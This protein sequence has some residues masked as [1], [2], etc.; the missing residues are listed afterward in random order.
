M[1]R[2]VKYQGR[3]PLAWVVGSVLAGVVG[4]TFL[5]GREGLAG[6]LVRVKGETGTFRMAVM[7]TTV[8]QYCGYLNRRSARSGENHPQCRRRAGRWVPRRGVARQPV[9]Y[10]SFD[11]VEA[12]CLWLAEETGLRVRLPSEEE[13]TIAA[14]AGDRRRKYPWGWGDPAPHAWYARRAATHVGCYEPNAMGLHDM[15][16]NV[17]EWC[18]TDEADAVPEVQRPVRGGS[19]AETSHEMLAIANRVLLPRGYRDADVG[20]RIVVA[21]DP[22]D[23]VE[24]HGPGSMKED[25]VMVE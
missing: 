6:R 24:L 7:E 21:G 12:Y 20:F 18:T 19:W 15:A 16:G 4:F 9:A 14:A 3:F 10:V 23:T 25:R 5:A 1:S 8:A 13:W 11:D 17:F 22:Q 2:T